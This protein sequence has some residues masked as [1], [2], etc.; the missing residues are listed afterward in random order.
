M[1]GD[2]IPSFD[3]QFYHTN[4]ETEAGRG[5]YLMIVS[6]YENGSV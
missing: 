1:G 2:I 6:E 3:P 4:F 5:G